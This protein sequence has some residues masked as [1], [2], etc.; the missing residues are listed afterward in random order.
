M[1]SRRRFVEQ[2]AAAAIATTA[3]LRA[4]QSCAA[5]PKGDRALPAAA[6]R[7]K[8]AIRRDD[9]LLRLGGDG[10]NFHMSWAADDR[11][12]V[13]ICDGSGWPEQSADFRNSRLFAI[14]GG[15]QEAVFESLPGYP[16]KPLWD[17]V[18]EITAPYYGFG[19]LA[20]DGCVY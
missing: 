14:R 19:T 18:D 11:Q 16:D 17:M 8:S 9:T 15:P 13:A 4:V 10:D 20:L 12:L 1:V 5:E 6:A 2:A 7:V 3:C